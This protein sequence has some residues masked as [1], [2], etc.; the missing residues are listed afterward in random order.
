MPSN[1]SSSSRP[2]ETPRA[3]RVPARRSHTGMALAGAVVIAGGF[4]IAV[5]EA[6][7][8]PKG[9]VWAIVGVTAAVAALIRAISRRRR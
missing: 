4:A 9:S 6:L 7:H 1:D 2:P 8:Y 3:P 5:G